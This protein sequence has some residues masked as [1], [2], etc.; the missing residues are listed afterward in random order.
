[1]TNLTRIAMSLNTWAA[2]VLV[3]AD[4]HESGVNK[5]DVLAPAQKGVSFYCLVEKPAEIVCHAIN[6]CNGNVC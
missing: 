4:A 6:F 5:V 1:M 2:D 3:V